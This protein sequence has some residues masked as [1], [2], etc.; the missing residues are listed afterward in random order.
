MAVKVL[1]LIVVFVGICFNFVVGQG[2]FGGGFGNGNGGGGGFMRGGFS[3]IS[4]SLTPQQREQVKA[5]FMDPTTPKYITK[6]KLRAFFQRI[7]GNAAV[8]FLILK[9]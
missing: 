7:G 3:E 2:F 9:I 5:I 4:Q 6:Q 8:K 1:G